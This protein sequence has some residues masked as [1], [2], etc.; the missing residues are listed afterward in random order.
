MAQ[1]PPLV[2]LEPWN[3]WVEERIEALC[4][5]NRLKEVIEAIR[6]VHPYEEVAMDIYPLEDLS[7]F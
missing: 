1:S 4:E 3:L 5:K 2:K 6:V 7:N